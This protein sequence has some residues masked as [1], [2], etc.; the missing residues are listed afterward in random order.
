MTEEPSPHEAVKTYQLGHAPLMYALP[1]GKISAGKTD[2]HHD[3]QDRL[4]R[5]QAKP[6]ADCEMVALPPGNHHDMRGM[7][8]TCNSKLR[9]WWR[10]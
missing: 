10:W 8:P 9:G 5:A 6:K 1:G 4:T 2:V 7:L 3:L